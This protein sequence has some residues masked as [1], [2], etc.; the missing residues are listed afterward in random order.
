MSSEQEIQLETSETPENATNQDNVIAAYKEFIYI[1]HNGN[2]CDCNG[3]DCLECSD[4]SSLL[5]GEIDFPKKAEQVFG[6]DLSETVRC[7][8]NRCGLPNVKALKSVPGGHGRTI[9]K[10]LKNIEADIVFALC[11]CER[12]Q[13]TA[14]PMAVL[15][16]APVRITPE[17]E[18]IRVP[19][20]QK[21]PLAR[22]LTKITLTDY[23]NERTA[24]IIMIGGDTVSEGSYLGAMGSGRDFTHKIQTLD[25]LRLAPMTFQQFAVDL[26]ER[27]ITAG[28][29]KLCSEEQL[30]Q[31]YKDILKPVSDIQV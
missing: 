10:H 3:V 19:I 31:K 28:S 21:L 1:P 2:L 7:S 26:L 18:L 23:H 6:L 16:P 4:L 25:F 20:S 8:N 11:E 14:F 24:K 17:T 30:Q 27:E 15:S 9:W 22:L 13:L 12:P 29:Q 5:T